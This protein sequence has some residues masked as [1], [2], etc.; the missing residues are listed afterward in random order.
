MKNRI[1]KHGRDMRKLEWFSIAK[2][3]IITT[4]LA[5]IAFGL[6]NLS[7]TVRHLIK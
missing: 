2:W 3:I 1:T 6:F 5:L 7:Y 4:A